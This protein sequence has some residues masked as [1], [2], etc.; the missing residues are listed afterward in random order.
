MSLSV[1]VPTLNARDELA[2]CLDALAEY[3]PDAEVIVVN[4]PSADGTTG[5]VRDRPGVDVLVE[6]ADRAINAARNAG[7]DHATGEAVAF[8]N[9][10]LSVADSWREAVADGLDRGD[11]VTGPTRTQLR[12]GL[13]T[14][15]KESR[16]VAGT[17]VTYFNP[18]NV[19]FR[20]E[21][22][23]ALDGFDEYL[24]IGGARDA[25]HRLAA[26]GYEMAWDDGMCVREEVGADGGREI[27]W[28]W[29]HRSLAY[30]LVKNYGLRPTVLRR[31]ASH[32]GGDA[33]A[34][35]RRVARGERR[36]S[37]WLGTGREVVTGI[38]VGIKDGLAARRRDEA[39]RRNPNGWSARSDRA[40]TVYD[41][42]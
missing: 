31:L 4:G 21:L 39:P 8:V 42:R 12:V 29:K 33:A 6:I 22:L 34:G 40:V 19:A 35:L 26:A 36:P 28:E 27:A 9:H 14:E 38:A 20:R 32:V 13:E 1:V 3:A 17:A 7:L 41:R 11:A 10:T 23:A 16:T 5:M 30:R 18:G 2:D 15:R 24:E 37:T 25:A